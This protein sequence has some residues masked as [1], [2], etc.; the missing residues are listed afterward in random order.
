MGKAQKCYNALHRKQLINAYFVLHL[1]LWV[2]MHVPVELRDEYLH[3]FI[4]HH[5]PFVHEGNCENL[6]FKF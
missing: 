1:W 6:T 4:L 3:D 2:Y 5:F